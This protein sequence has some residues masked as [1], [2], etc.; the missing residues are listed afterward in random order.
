MAF[1]IVLATLA[2]V[3][4]FGLPAGA[5]DHGVRPA[6]GLVPDAE[7][8]IAIAVAVWGPI[9]G[10]ERIRRQRPYVATLRDGRWT[11]QGSLPRAALGGVAIAVIARE[12]ARVL[13][14]SHGR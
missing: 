1:R 13:R 14:V 8:A 10:A 7:T 2:A 5:Q 12:D 6:G 11:V 4:L 3:S 9:Y